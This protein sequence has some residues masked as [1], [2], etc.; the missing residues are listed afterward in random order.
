[1][2]RLS[3]EQETSLLALLR[4]AQ[5]SEHPAVDDRQAL[6]DFSRVLTDLPA[7]IEARKAQAGRGRK[8]GPARALASLAA[9]PYHAHTGNNPGRAESAR[10]GDKNRPGGHYPRLVVMLA[11]IAGEPCTLAKAANACKAEMDGMNDRLNLR[12]LPRKRRDGDLPPE[13]DAARKRL[14][15]THS[16]GLDD[17]G[18]PVIE[19][20]QPASDPTFNSW[21][22]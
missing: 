8:S 10:S 12:K 4:A 11:D 13:R 18:E 19:G 6:L 21:K 5:R 9:E 20:Y 1:M 15:S 17:N 2:K 7:E 14:L 22:P 3:P 16:D